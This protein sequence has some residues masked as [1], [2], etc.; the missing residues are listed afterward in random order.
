MNLFR[1]KKFSQVY[2]EKSS[3]IITAYLFLDKDITFIGPKKSTW[4]SC[5][6][7]VIELNSLY[8]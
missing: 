2:L 4:I 7:V 6:G 5:R 8:L 3:T 1:M